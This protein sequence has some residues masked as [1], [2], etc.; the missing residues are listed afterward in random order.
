MLPCLSIADLF[1]CAVAD[2]EFQS[3]RAGGLSNRLQSSYFP[4]FFFCHFGVVPIFSTGWIDR[5]AFVSRIR[6]WPRFRSV[7]P[8]ND[9]ITHI[10][11]CGPHKQMR[12]INARRVVAFV[13]GL[14]SAWY[15]SISD[16]Q[17]NPRCNENCVSYSKR[18]V[19][20]CMAGCSPH[21]AR[22]EFQSN[23]GTVLVHLCPKSFLVR[24]SQFGNCANSHMRSNLSLLVSV[25]RWLNSIGERDN[26]DTNNFVFND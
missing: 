6:I 9:H 11:K 16:G 15:A 8:L 3:K 23:Y 12:R 13:K 25:F 7:S 17:R 22:S 10:V 26:I 2:S 18:A 24:I 5:S 21:P 1:S 4:Y 14:K 19:A 20:I